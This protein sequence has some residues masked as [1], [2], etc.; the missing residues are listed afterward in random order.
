MPHFHTKEHRGHLPSLRRFPTDL[1]RISQGSPKYLPSISQGSS[2][3]LRSVDRDAFLSEIHRDFNPISVCLETA[4]IGSMISDDPRSRDTDN[5]KASSRCITNLFVHYIF[6]VESIFRESRWQ[7]FEIK[8]VRREAR[9]TIENFRH[10]STEY[11]LTL[12]T[13]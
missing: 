12:S 9:P 5:R 3:D 11:P 10:C 4:L 13:D 7:R 2:K 1:P 6:A 8:R